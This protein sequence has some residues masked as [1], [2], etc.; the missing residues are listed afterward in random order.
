MQQRLWGGGGRGRC[1]AAYL[2]VNHRCSLR[3]TTRRNPKR[4]GVSHCVTA[5]TVAARGCARQKNGGGECCST[6]GVTKSRDCECH[7]KHVHTCACGCFLHMQPEQTTMHSAPHSLS[8]YSFSTV[9]NR[10]N[11]CNHSMRWC[12]CISS[13]TPPT[14]QS[15]PQ[16]SAHCCRSW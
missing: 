15:P 13:A 1:A 11:R 12:C 2:P 3:C 14:L 6:L 7:F 8:K 9:R 10:V 4:A 5:V 16:R